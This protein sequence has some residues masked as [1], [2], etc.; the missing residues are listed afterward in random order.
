MAKVGLAR[1]SDVPARY[2]QEL[3]W[4]LRAYQWFNKRHPDMAR[5]IRVFAIPGKRYGFSW[6]TGSG[7]LEKKWVPGMSSYGIWSTGGLYTQAYVDYYILKNAPVANP[8][9]KRPRK[10]AGYDDWL[11]QKDW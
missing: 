6:G 11:R 1:W 2:R 10:P 4:W 8:P 7:K 5:P 9:V 3:S